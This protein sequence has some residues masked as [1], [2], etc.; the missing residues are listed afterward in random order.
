MLLMYGLVDAHISG[1]VSVLSGSFFAKAILLPEALHIGQVGRLHEPGKLRHGHG[2]RGRH[3]FVGTFIAA[4]VDRLF[5]FPMNVHRFG[6]MLL[7]K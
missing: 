1:C 7:Y 5:L 3:P 6:I 4:D 2:K